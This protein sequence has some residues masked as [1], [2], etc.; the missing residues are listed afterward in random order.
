MFVVYR[1]V[2]GGNFILPRWW[3]THIFEVTNV[4]AKAGTDLYF[5]GLKMVEGWSIESDEAI[6]SDLNLKLFLLL[7]C[8]FTCVAI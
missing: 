4:S 8:M 5:S 2:N 3:D 1:S 7:Y 6:S